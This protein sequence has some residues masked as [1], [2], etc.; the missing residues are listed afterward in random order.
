MVNPSCISSFKT[1]ASIDMFF[2]HEP[3]F[4]EL[5]QLLYFL[6]YIVFDWPWVSNVVL[7][8]KLF[9]SKP[10]SCR[11]VK[12]CWVPLCKILGR[13]AQISNMRSN[14]WINMRFV[15]S[16]G[17]PWNAF[18]IESTHIDVT[19]TKAFLSRWFFWFSYS[20]ERSKSFWEASI[21]RWRWCMRQPEEESM[22]R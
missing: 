10:K 8:V 11:R 12:C 1:L 13:L 7:Q 2:Q 22:G 3:S 16:K 15:Q 5:L 14:W 6:L 17:S 4:A 9:S 21:D 18:P 19:M 20:I